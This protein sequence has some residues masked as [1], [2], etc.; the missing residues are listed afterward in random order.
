MEQRSAHA[1]LALAGGF[2]LVSSLA[3]LLPLLA[4]KMQRRNNYVSVSY[5]V[6]PPIR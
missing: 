6:F 2:T 3:L 4:V 1:E 5:D